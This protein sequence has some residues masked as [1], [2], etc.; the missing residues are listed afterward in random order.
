MTEER[1]YVVCQKCGR[2]VPTGLVIEPL[3]FEQARET[4]AGNRTRCESCG[5]WTVWRHT[6]VWPESVVLQRFGKLPE[7]R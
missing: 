4:F 3:T 1:I 6:K 2:P 5:T 7:S